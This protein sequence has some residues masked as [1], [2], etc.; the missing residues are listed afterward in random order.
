MEPFRGETPH[1]R[2]HEALERAGLA[3][4]ELARSWVRAA[5]EALE[6][7][8]A[9]VL[10]KVEEGRFGPEEPLALGY[11]FELRR[12]QRLEAS[13]EAIDR[14]DP[15]E[16]Q[17]FMEIFRVR[18]DPDEEDPRLLT[19]TWSEPSERVLVHEAR[20]T[21]TYILRVQPELLS[22]GAYRVS[23]R[24]GPGLAFPVEGRDTGAIR[25]TFGAPRD[26]GRREHHGVD[27]FAPRGTPVLSAGE[28]RVSRVSETSVGGRVVWVRDEERGMS[29]Y[30]AH[31]DT[32]LVERGA[33]VQAGDT[34]GTVG[35]TGNARTTPPH[36]HF[37]LYVRGEGPVDPWFWL[38]DPGGS[39]APLRVE[40]NAFREV[41]H[42]AEA[43]GAIRIGPSDR[44]PALERVEVREPVRIVGGTGTYYRVRLADGRQGYASPSSLMLLPEEGPPTLLPLPGTTTDIGSPAG[45]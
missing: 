20:A 16:P 35:N 43:S 2:Y 29:V 27:I 26:G 33:R 23:L 31:L 1:E 42:L 4:S 22:G 36:L 14:W 13:F 3:E 11:R 8:V 15:D 19:L 17:V 28:G 25:S 37:G 10:P 7:P 39:P 44:S 6:A 38:H 9:A 24:T 21:G 5:R 32:Q 41:R 34:L 18:G 30:Y 45:R 40:R 12:G